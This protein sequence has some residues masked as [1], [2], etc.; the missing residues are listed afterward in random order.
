MLIISRKICSL[1]I[2]VSVFDFPDFKSLS[3]FV[4]GLQCK[5]C[6]KLNN[7]NYGNY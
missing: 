3:W 5:N 4:S 1:N 7:Y 6:I 2:L